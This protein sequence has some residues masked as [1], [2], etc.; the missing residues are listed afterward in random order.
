[1]GLST[2]IITFGSVAVQFPVP[3]D[4]PL[5]HLVIAEPLRTN[6]A[7]CYVGGSNVTNDGSGTGVIRELAQPGASTAFVDQF[8]YQPST[9]GNRV[10]PTI[11][12]AHGTSGQ[13]LKLTYLKV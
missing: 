13:K 3:N 9:D 2:T 10:D 1:M 12:W 8:A 6:G 7:V 5:V 4:L 11:F